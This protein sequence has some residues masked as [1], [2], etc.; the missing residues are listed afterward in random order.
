M[1]PQQIIKITTLDPEV[2]V[3]AVLEINGTPVPGFKLMKTELTSSSEETEVTVILI[4][5]RVEITSE[6]PL[7]PGV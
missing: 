1:N 6:L 3:N 7:D 5:K 2:G 4:A